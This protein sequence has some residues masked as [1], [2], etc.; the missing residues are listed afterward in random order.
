MTTYILVHGA[1]VGGGWSWHTVVALDLPG[2]GSDRTPLKQVTL[3]KYVN[4][5]VF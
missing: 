4:R 5:V 3:Q 1:F 2:S